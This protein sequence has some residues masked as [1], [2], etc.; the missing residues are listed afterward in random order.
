MKDLMFQYALYKLTKAP[1]DYF[2]LCT[3]YNKQIN[4]LKKKL[5][6]HKIRGIP[7]ILW[8]VFIIIIFVCII[9]SNY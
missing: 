5:E 9:T 1:V 7:L 3:G 6:L 8:Q 4:R 2:R